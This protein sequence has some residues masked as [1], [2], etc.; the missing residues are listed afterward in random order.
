MLPVL[1]GRATELATVDRV[2][3]LAQ[4]QR[5]ALVVR[6]GPGIGKSTIWQAAIDA[7][8]GRSVQVLSARPIQSEAPLPLSGFGDL[9][10]QLPDDV[11]ARLP[12][13]Q[14]HA[15]DVALLRAEPADRPADQRTLAVAT[16]SLLRTLSAAAP[17][18]VA[19]DDAQWFD[20]SSARLLAYALRRVADRPVG[21]VVTILGSS[22]SP[23]LGIDAW[24]ER[25]GVEDLT[26]HS[27]SVAALHQILSS[28]LATSFSRLA[29]VR[30]HAECAGNPFYA[31]EIARDLIRTQASVTPGR[32]LPVPESLAT[33][34]SDRIARLPARTRRALVMAA[35]ALE[36]PSLATL[37]AAGIDDP[38]KALRPAVRDGIVSAGSEVR[39]AH[40]LLAAGALAG[41]D[42][43]DIQGAHAALARVADSADL[44][45]RHAAQAASGPDER[46]AAG[47]AQ[48]GARIRER[49]APIAGGELLEAAV[50]L[51]PPTREA[52]AAHRMHQAAEWYF[53]GGEAQRAGVLLEQL[54]HELPAG[55]RRARALQL[56]GQ[57]RARSMSIADALGLAE[58]A[59]REA[60]GDIGAVAAIELDIAFYAFCLG[61]LP[62]TLPHARAA[63]AQAT[64]AGLKGLRADALACVTMASFWLGNGYREE[65]IAQAIRDEDPHRTGPLE[66]QPRFVGALL[67]LWTGCSAEAVAELETLRRELVDRGQETA[68]PFLSLFL[69]IGH[70]YHGDLASAGDV[71][72]EAHATAALNGEPVPL[73]LARAAQALVEA[74]AGNVASAREA[75]GE[76][77]ATFQ[78][79]QW[80]IYATW[81]L[82]AMGLVELSLNRPAQVDAVLTPLA[83]GIASLP[84]ADPVLGI[85]LPE[86]IEALV[87][88]GE[89]SRAER[90]LAWL[91]AR[92][93]PLDRPWAMAVAAR[94]RGLLAAATDPDLALRELDAAIEHHAR[95]D[96]PFELA[97]TL[98]AKGQVHRR[99][100]EKRLAQQALAQAVALFEGTGARA[101]VARARHELARVG[102]RPR[103][104]GGLTEA[105]L[106]VAQLVAEGRTTRQVAELAFLSPKTV[107]NV[108]GRVYR[109]LGIT[110][111]A[112]LGATMAAMARKSS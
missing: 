44:R 5:A 69:V 63:L 88:L 34:T 78:E 61:D 18:L 14:Q 32:P 40:P 39:F 7:A 89:R 17:L 30:I 74:R 107:D 70:L 68:L 101:W 55:L 51:T 58:R 96:M 53:A 106:R 49:G 65:A 66:M 10:L 82:W 60:E 16:T 41:V 28:R 29:M 25:S 8:R 57:V 84:A 109:K 73:A 64:A 77:A 80:A 110:S 62:S 104:S 87:A 111:R 94:G 50:A 20:D 108:L 81:P 4:S 48:A 54:V 103:A 3:D 33:L 12:P 100:R 31:L 38:H 59:L 97:R 37:A 85:V 26:L 11:S 98:L 9:F 93:R 43:A 92:G 105:E 47:L 1:I 24:S 45:A 71:A 52:D 76:A 90:Y 13:P 102:L 83:D 42:R 36:P 99:R 19:I 35:V 95:L 21:V 67:L 75:A 86:E 79:S 2:L 27:L 72:T 56:L 23:P 46:V 22:G 112:E 6:G 91:D 15:L